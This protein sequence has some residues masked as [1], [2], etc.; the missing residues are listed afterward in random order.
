V[1]E[2]WS[3]DLSS[4]RLPQRDLTADTLAD[5]MRSCLDEPG[6]RSRAANLA[7]RIRAEDGAGAVLALVDAL[8]E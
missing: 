6:Y 8:A 3:D 2:P 4:N 1:P 7:G 5:A